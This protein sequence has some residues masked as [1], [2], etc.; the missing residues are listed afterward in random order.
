MNATLNQAIHVLTTLRAKMEAF[1]D[2]ETH[3]RLQDLI[4]SGIFFDLMEVK[5]PLAIDREEFRRFIGVEALPLRDAFNI[6]VNF[7]QNTHNVLQ[8]CQWAYQD[9]PADYPV[10][11][12]LYT[13]KGN[14]L[15]VPVG[16]KRVTNVVTEWA[17]KNL[18]PAGFRETLI[19]ACSTDKSGA[20]ICPI[21][22]PVPAGGPSFGGVDFRNW[23][24]YR[25]RKGRMHLMLYGLTPKMLEAEIDGCMIR[26]GN[27][28]LYIKKRDMFIAMLHPQTKEG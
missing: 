2:G 22:V 20:Y 10:T 14:V 5:H 7:D 16:W 11:P 27:S 13:G 8:H 26:G 18:V 9:D 4:D 15:C 1:C 21:P 28:P 24:V 19:A 23:I 6:P 12:H 17:K 3:D 25:D